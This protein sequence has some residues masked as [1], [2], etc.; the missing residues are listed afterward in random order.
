MK[1]KIMTYL[2]NAVFFVLGL[3]I[4]KCA[5]LNNNDSL[6]ESFIPAITRTQNKLSRNMRR[7]KE[8]ISEKYDELIRKTN[9]SFRQ[10]GIPGYFK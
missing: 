9:R 4:L 1:K 5:L 2:V 6:K 10:T 8:T 3:L 7:T